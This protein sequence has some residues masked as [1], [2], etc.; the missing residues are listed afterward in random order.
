M[1]K[2]TLE[3]WRM[4]VAVVKYGGFNQ[5]SV[6]IHKSQSS[7]HHAVQKLEESLDIKLLEVIG[8]KASLTDAGS[9]MLK[10]ANYLLDEAAKIEAVAQS[11]NE[12]IENQLRIA[13]DE[14]FPQDII[15][16]LLDSTSTQYPL[17]TIELM[18]SVLMGS[19]ELL[20][21]TKVDIAISPYPTRKGFCEELCNIEF[22]AVAHPD[23]ALHHMENTISLEDLKS[24]RQIVVR[25]SSLNNPQDD[26]WLIANQRWTVSHLKTS[27]E[28]I[29][30]GLGFAWL[31]LSTIIKELSTAQL[32][33]IPLK[34]SGTRTCQL[35]L[36]Y[37]DVDRLGP[38]ARS[39][40]HEIRTQCLNLPTIE[41]TCKNI[42]NASNS[43]RIPEK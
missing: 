35:Y 18:E 33:P 32:K 14:V 17:L 38:A 11:I 42:I 19:N 13:V 10:R 2:V 34:H 6:V 29:S 1:Y 25:D 41:N 39:F 31:P 15:C 28:M 8:R 37:A 5:A 22:I 16:Q 27:V 3:Q 43:K 12:G 20:E 30:A 23:H 26:G 36:I 7:I 4:F 9:L 40:I 24:H 21:N